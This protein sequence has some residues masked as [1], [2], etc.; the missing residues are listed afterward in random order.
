M[1]SR[2]ALS[3]IRTAFKS[4]TIN[5]GA[6]RGATRGFATVA[7]NTARSKGQHMMGVSTGCVLGIGF[8]QVVVSFVPF[9]CAGLMHLAGSR[10]DTV[11]PFNC[12]P[13]A[14]HFL[15]QNAFLSRTAQWEFLQ[16]LQPSTRKP[17]LFLLPP[18]PRRHR[19][20]C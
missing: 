17:G 1:F 7:A 14:I 18:L 4:T 20:R 8:I 6:V 3:L 2:R 9:W 10:V 12:Y 11:M 13:L 15:F 5:A 19:H 16:I